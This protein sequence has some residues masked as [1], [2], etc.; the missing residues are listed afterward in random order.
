MF[1]A[2]KM[3]GKTYINPLLDEA[4]HNWYLD[5]LKEPILEIGCGNGTLLEYLKK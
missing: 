5:Y 4:M 3:K 2:V 1:E